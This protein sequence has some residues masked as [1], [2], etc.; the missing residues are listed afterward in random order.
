MPN[1]TTPQ[2]NLLILI[3]LVVCVLLPVVSSNFILSV[4]STSYQVNDPASLTINIRTSTTITTLDVI[5]SNVFVVASPA[6]RVNG[7]AVSCNR[8]VPATGALVYVRFSYSFA[9]STNYTLFFNITNPSYS[10][11]FSIQ[12]NNG[13]TAFGNTGSLTINPKTI[14]C[15]MA[16]SSPV[17]SLTANATFLLSVSTMNSGT[18]GKLSISVNSQTAFPNVINTSPVCSVD[19]SSVACTLGQVFGV[20]ILSISDVNV[21][22]RPNGTQLNLFVNSVK[23]SPFNATFVH[24]LL[25]RRKVLPYQSKTPWTEIL[26]N[27][28]SPSLHQQSCRRAL[29]L[30]CKVG[31]LWSDRSP[32][33]NF[34]SP[35][36]MHLWPI[37]RSS[38]SMNCR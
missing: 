1:P 37:L 29:L 27:A 24:F 36:F 6:C 15:S 10:D 25:M 23:N 9:A 3:T 13:A 26:R 38:L 30:L 12:A 5:L 16:S 17:V 20:Q 32:M 31:V 35:H 34:Y 33:P 8:I 22:I 2:Q 21:G 18:M 28:Y 4:S 19:G 11:S 7:V 14:T